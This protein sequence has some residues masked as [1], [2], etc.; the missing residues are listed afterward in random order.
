MVVVVLVRVLDLVLA[1]PDELL[2]GLAADDLHDVGHRGGCAG[3]DG[4]GAWDGRGTET[5]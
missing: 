4:E 1:G 3:R 2:V 5:T